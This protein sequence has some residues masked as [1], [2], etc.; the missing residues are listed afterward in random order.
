MFYVVRLFIAYFLNLV[1]YF[2]TLYWVKNYGI[3]IESNP[4]GKW[5]F[6]NDLAGFV[7]IFVVG[8]LFLILALLSK[9]SKKAI[10]AG[11]LLVTVYSIVVIYHTFLAFYIQ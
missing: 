8:I 7:K 11:T 6:E 10:T 5:L 3:D 4:I 2:F 9:K 1:D